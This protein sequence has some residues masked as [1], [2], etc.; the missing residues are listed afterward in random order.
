[1]S[2]ASTV[3]PVTID[4]LPPVS[5]LILMPLLKKEWSGARSERIAGIWTFWLM[6]LVIGGFYLTF[7][8]FDPPVFFDIARILMG[9]IGWFY[10]IVLGAQTVC[11]DW[12]KAEEHFARSQPVTPRAIIWAKWCSG[13]LLL[14]MIFGPMLI[15]GGL[16]DRFDNSYG[17]DRLVM[18]LTVFG[19]MVAGYA[20]AFAVAVVTRHTLTG[21]L[22]AILVL[23]TWWLMPLLSR[24]LMVLYPAYMTDTVPDTEAGLAMRVGV[25]VLGCGVFAFLN[26]AVAWW[27]APRESAF[28]PSGKSIA[29]TA[30]AI[31]LLAFSAAMSEVGSSLKVV[32]QSPWPEFKAQFGDWRTDQYGVP[33]GET[34]VHFASHDRTA[35]VLQRTKEG[36]ECVRVEIDSDGE[37]QTSDAVNL[38]ESLGL[39][40]VH[41]HQP[42]DWVATGEDEG[43]VIVHAAFGKVGQ[44]YLVRA[45]FRWARDGEPKWS[46]PSI[47]PLDPYPQ[48]T[49]R[50]FASGDRYTYVLTSML[51][52][53]DEPW[54]PCRLDIYDW[55]DASASGPRWSQELF[56]TTMWMGEFGGQL[57][58]QAWTYHG[59]EFRNNTQANQYLMAAASVPLDD[60]EQ[61]LK[62]IAS[63]RWT[64]TSS[65]WWRFVQERHY[66]HMQERNVIF[67]ADQERFYGISFQSFVVRDG[68]LE[69][70]GE[71]RFSP[72][73]VM[74]RSYD[75]SLSQIDADRVLETG[76]SV[77]SVFDVSD[78]RR[79]RRTGY[80]NVAS[81]GGASAFSLDDHL[82]LFEPGMLTVLE[83]PEVAHAHDSAGEADSV[84][85]E[86][87]L[88]R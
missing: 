41:W 39:E 38:A 1:M 51:R 29:W 46:T 37:I 73:A 75:T 9:F 81:R 12:G 80:F 34:P 23:A 54:E 57:A 21:I 43:R 8:E 53:K 70:L 56:Y 60:P 82:L 11:R 55:D 76:R 19:V 69:E 50:H 48:R 64:D 58:L 47:R 4:S 59:D 5:R 28:N 6:P 67:C 31:V 86:K 68:A 78:P 14:V 62:T 52:D 85:K 84:D 72:L 49:H 18:D 83:L 7:L 13:L 65:P 16:A 35:F 36:L 66:S 30:V 87:P 88:G 15:L 17:H 22:I 42:V 2:N 26:L 74:F 33:R 61:L 24:R 40:R 45:E 20:V 3:P 44:E 77:L 10:A 63:R 32:D 27:F 25:F 79:P 71:Y